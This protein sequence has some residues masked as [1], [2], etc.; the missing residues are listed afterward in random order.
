MHVDRRA[1]S[2]LMSALPIGA[3]ER[4]LFEVAADLA[5]DGHPVDIVTAGASAEWLAHVPASVR[6]L[7][8]A[9]WSARALARVNP[10]R[11]T[12]ALPAL[13]NYMARARPAVLLTASIPPALTALSA[14]QLCGASTRIIVRQSNVLN[15]PNHATY[16]A[17]RRRWRD[18]LVR[19]LYPA[20]D[21]FVAVSRGVA[22]N[23]R[24]VIAAPKPMQVIY[25]HVI[26]SDF[27]ARAAVPVDHPWLSD[28]APP[29]IIAVGRLVAKKDYS[30]LLRA[31]AALARDR[32]EVRLLILGEGPER[33]RLQ[34]LGAELGIEHRLE[35]P[36]H[37]ANPLPYLRRAALY[38]LS[39]IS[40]GMPSALV[41]ALACGCSIVATDCPSGPAEILENGAFGRLVPVRNPEALHRAMAAGLNA[42][43]PAE[44]LTARAAD[45]AACHGIAAY[46]RTLLAAADDA[47][48]ESA[49]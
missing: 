49:P 33:A 29:C 34:T 5:S 22:D 13:A 9:P 45:F 8:L 31:F 18:A 26:T 48:R 23:L 35:L 40:E 3:R 7:N 19:R 11:L 4:L 47:L 37:V 44:R 39:S 20:A 38:V 24:H 14:R 36:G 15:I 27:A 10:V 2:L 42:P 6:A 16:G 17:V 32:P 1:I 12:L 25:N 46:R 21:G 43:P 28:G 30:T 41:E